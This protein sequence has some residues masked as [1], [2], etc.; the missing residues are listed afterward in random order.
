MLAKAVLGI[1][2]SASDYVVDWCCKAFSGSSTELVLV[3]CYA[4]RPELG[5][6][7]NDE[8]RAELRPE[9]DKACSKLRGAAVTCRAMLVDGDA[10]CALIETA[11]AEN[12]E[13]I[14]VGS[15]GAGQLSDL[16]I[17]SVASYLTHH[18]PLPVTVVR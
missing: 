1:D 5:E 9:L 16:V 15:H 2:G 3:S 13:L 10:R 14:I 7:A 18:S 17:G 6:A 11:S 8:L 4:P 12:C